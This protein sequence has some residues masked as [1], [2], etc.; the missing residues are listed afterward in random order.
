M[1]VVGVPEMTPVP[2]FRVSPAGK[3][4]AVRVKVYGPTP[5]EA[6]SVVEY[7]TLRAASGNVEL[8][9]SRVDVA[10]ATTLNHIDEKVDEPPCRVIVA[11]V[12]EAKVT[13]ATTSHRPGDNVPEIEHVCPD[14]NMPMLSFTHVAG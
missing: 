6:V 11:P 14:G 8:V 9:R 7:A 2:E 10:G 5:P 4:P 13:A 3:V 12:V 1:A